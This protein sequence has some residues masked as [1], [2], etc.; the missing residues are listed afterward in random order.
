MGS[1][2]HQ[3]VVYLAFICA[4]LAALRAFN[5][6]K[7]AIN[8]GLAICI[9]LQGTW[10]IQLGFLLYPPDREKWILPCPEIPASI[11]WKVKTDND[12]QKYFST[13]IED[14]EEIAHCV[15]VGRDDNAALLVS[16]CFAIHLLAVAVFVL[17]LTYAM[18]LIV[19]KRQLYGRC[20]QRQGSRCRGDSMETYNLVKSE[21]SADEAGP[22]C[23]KTTIHI[24][25]QTYDHSTQHEL[26]MEG[27]SVGD[28]AY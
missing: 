28:A 27:T 13:R 2:T 15:A 21:S 12:F 4:L 11:K 17:V 10:F 6:K 25:G 20:F 18:Q 16:F 9:V 14:N 1:Y 19:M 8:I 24:S 5:E 26:S 22:G 3:L 7:L 23:R